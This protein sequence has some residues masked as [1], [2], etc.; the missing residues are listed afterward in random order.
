[1]SLAIFEDGIG[2]PHVNVVFLSIDN[3]YLSTTCT[4]IYHDFYMFLYMEY[5]GFKM[6]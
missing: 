5:K 3:I 2:F 4:L 6:Y 1:M